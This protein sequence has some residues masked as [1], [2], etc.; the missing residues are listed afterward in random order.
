MK[1]TIV[2]IKVDIQPQY[3]KYE[4]FLIGVF[5]DETKMKEAI[6]FAENKYKRFQHII[7]KHKLIINQNNLG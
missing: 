3:G 6:S 5:D 1:T 7:S 4:R 2:Y